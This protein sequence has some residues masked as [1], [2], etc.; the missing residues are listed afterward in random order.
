MMLR[1][2]MRTWMPAAVL[3]PLA[4]LAGAVYSAQS[5]GTLVRLEVPTAHLQAGGQPFDVSVL[6]D[7]VT[8]LGAFEFELT[9]DPKVV[10]FQEAHEG[11]FLGSSGRS[12]YCLTPQ[13]VEGSLT[14]SCVT[15]G[16]TPDGPNGSGVLASVTLR[17]AGAGNSPL[18]LSRAVLTDPPANRLPTASQDA[19]VTVEGSGGSGGRPWILWGPAIGVIALVLAVAAGA[20]WRLRRRPRQ[21]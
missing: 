15:L 19:S 12:V 20:I 4:A 3:L 21:A 2:G 1:S 11:P 16:A 6:V 9:Y 17:P 7:N 8:N 18:R 5:Q 10:E 13:T 14:F